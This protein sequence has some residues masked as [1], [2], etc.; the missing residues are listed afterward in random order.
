MAVPAPAE[1]RQGCRLPAQGTTHLWLEWISGWKEMTE[2]KSQIKGNTRVWRMAGK[3]LNWGISRGHSRA[4]DDK[5]SSERQ[6]GVGHALF[7]LGERCVDDT[8]QWSSQKGKKGRGW[9]QAATP[10]RKPAWNAMQCR[11]GQNGTGKQVP[12]DRSRKAGVGACKASELCEGPMRAHLGP[13]S[14]GHGCGL[15]G[16]AGRDDS[17]HRQRL[18]C[19]ALP[20]RHGGGVEGL[21]GGIQQPSGRQL[22]AGGPQVAAQHCLEQQAAV[23]RVVVCDLLLAVPPGVACKAWEYTQAVSRLQGCRFGGE[24]SRRQTAGSSSRAIAASVECTGCRPSC[25]WC[26]AGRGSN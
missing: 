17:R 7:H 6:T 26:L 16:G 3:G 1:N 24:E 19:L 9:A 21:Q 20:R 13:S 15:G 14:R 25:T 22:G 12:G 18:C 2:K 8:L 10:P 11:E 5:A 4:I 23:P